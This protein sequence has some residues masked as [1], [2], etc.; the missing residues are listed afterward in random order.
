MVRPPAPVAGYLHSGLRPPAQPP[1]T[2]GCSR[3]L[4][5]VMLPVTYLNFLQLKLQVKMPDF[6]E[7]YL[8]SSIWAIAANFGWNDQLSLIT[9]LF[10]VTEAIGFLIS[11]QPFLTLSAEVRRFLHQQAPDNYILHDDLKH[12]RSCWKMIHADIFTD[13]G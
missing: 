1:H 7:F 2:T 6:A 4:T 12:C 11:L 10:V 8:M 3:Y 5:P 9:N 13:V